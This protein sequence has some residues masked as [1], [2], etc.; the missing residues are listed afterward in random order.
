MSW[1]KLRVFAG[2]VVV[3]VVA[4]TTL[5][6]VQA[7]S[8]RQLV[9]LARLGNSSGNLNFG[10]DSDKT[11][12]ATG[13][14]GA[15]VDFSVT[16]TDSQN[17]SVNV[18]CAP[19]SGSTFAIG[20]TPVQ[21]SGDDGSGNQGE[22]TFTV[23][24]QDT[25]PP[26]VQISPGSQKL[27]AAGANGAPASFSVS[28]NDS[29]DGSIGSFKCDH[30]SGDTYPVGT[31]T[32]TCTA[33]DN[34]GNQGQDQATI[35]VDPAAP[36]DTTPPTVKVPN[37]IT[38]TAT[39]ANGAAVSFAT[40][41]TDDVDGSVPVT[42]DHNSGDTFAVGTTTVSCSATDKSNNVGHGSF[43]VVVNDPGVTWS[44]VADLTAE[45]TG[46]K[47]AAV[48][49][50]APT[51]V[52]PA[53]GPLVPSCGPASGSTFALGATAVTCN[54][55]GSSTA[56]KVKVVDTTKPTL[57]SPGSITVTGTDPSGVGAGT[58]A[59]KSFL[60][61]K[62]RDLVDP[63]P[64]VKN[65]APNVFGYGT[66]K[67]RFTATDHSGNSTSATGSVTVVH[68]S[69]STGNA[70]SANSAVKIDRTPP[71][72]VSHLVVLVSGRS[73]LLK[74][75]LPT[76]SDFDHAT[77]VRQGPAGSSRVLYTGKKLGVLDRPINYG[78][79]YRYLIT[80]FDR[81]GNA[82]TGVAAIAMAKPLMLLAPAA[83]AN[84]GR[85]VQLRWRTVSGASYYNLQLFL[86]GKKVLS[87]W[88]TKPVF[89]LNAQWKWGGKVHRLVRGGSYTWFIWPGLGPRKQGKYGRLEG[90]SNFKVVK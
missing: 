35:E 43:K 88:P 57:S 27:A 32:V 64:T 52:D 12:E 28:A 9:G 41:A 16:A 39:T 40:S 53:K 6:V 3:A 77:V 23:T 44:Q 65:D 61:L 24:V 68:Q 25:T 59:I 79:Q 81:A 56:F 36:T 80:T 46:P 62:A 86:D 75:W 76:D 83:G 60:D 21:C 42:C 38:T 54:A 11:V 5:L 58:A 15:S 55:G 8:A 29:V 47:G 49:Y 50:T 26:N 19:A 72:N 7:A 84:V 63:H 4:G 51:A 73:V 22:T 67:V 10:G 17:N 70:V 45:A 33:K 34:A 90:F 69:A 2:L 13:A 30:N 74:W 31:T 66:T 82:S 18:T 20:D 1:A 89:A 87:I 14:N 85:P 37:D 48:P 78:V 71:A